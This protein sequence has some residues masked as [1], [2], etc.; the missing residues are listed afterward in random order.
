M[1]ETKKEKIIKKIKTRLRR[2]FNA[3]SQVANCWILWGYEDESCSSRFY[4]W[5]KKD[6]VFWKIPAKV[7]D[8]FLFWD[9]IKKD[10]VIIGHCEKSYHNEVARSGVPF[11][12]RGKKCAK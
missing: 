4:R 12:L 11:D 5:S 1:S 3:L 10:G 7:V 8:T 2:N 9:K 6:G